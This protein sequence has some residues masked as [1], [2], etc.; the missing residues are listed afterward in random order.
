MIVMHIKSHDAM[1]IFIMYLPHKHTVTFFEYTNSIL[2][3]CIGWN[4]DTTS[5]QPTQYQ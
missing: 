2:T 1:C 3:T 5:K 4:D